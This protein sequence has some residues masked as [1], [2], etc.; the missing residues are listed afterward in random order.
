MICIWYQASV[1]IGYP[2]AMKHPWFQ[3]QTGGE[4]GWTWFI[5]LHPWIS[6]L[7]NKLKQSNQIRDDTSGSPLRGSSASNR[8]EEAWPGPLTG[9]WCV[10]LLGTLL[11]VFDTW[12]HRVL[13]MVF[14]PKAT[15]EIILFVKIW[16][17]LIGEWRSVKQE[18]VPPY[19]W[20]P[21]SVKRPYVWFLFDT[22]CFDPSHDLMR[23]GRGLV[24]SPMTPSA[25][26]CTISQSCASPHAGRLC[27]RRWLLCEHVRLGDGE[28]GR[29]L[30]LYPSCMEQYGSAVE[31][32]V[33]IFPRLVTVQSSI[34]V[35]PLRIVSFSSW[36]R[37][38]V[39]FNW[40]RP[41]VC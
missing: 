20:F 33:S 6:E 35:G 41:V 9:S 3:T 40:G 28:V 32:P 4:F 34:R 27:C 8:L 30:W 16:I 13:L 2:V 31:L 39:S 21:T 22:N 14:E 1:T 7:W 37:K 17:I 18:Q 26:A 36:T 15:S 38:L 29:W 5:M 12:L 19:V 24:C 10:F 23:T 11:G 25:S